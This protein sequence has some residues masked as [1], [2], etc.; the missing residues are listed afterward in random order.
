MG[1][2]E[3]PW[4]EGSPYRRRELW[5]KFI[6]WG[7]IAAGFCIGGALCYLSYA[8][9]PRH[10]F[11][12]IMDDHFDNLDNWEYEIQTGG[13]GVGAFDWTTND[14]QNSYVSNN[15]LHIVPTLTL[16]STAITPDELVNGYT[17]N[18]TLHGGCTSNVSTDCGVT[19]NS[20]SGVIINPVR[21]ARLTTK[22]KKTITY[23]RIEVVAKMPA[24]DWLWP[25]IWMMPQDSV[26]GPWPRSGEMDLFESRGNNPKHYGGGINTAISTLHWGLNLETDMFQLTS[27][28][29]ILRRSDYSKGFHTFGMEWT[30]NYIYTYIDSRLVR[31]ISVGFGGQNMWQ[32][33]GLSSGRYSAQDPWSQTGRDNTPFDQ[34]FYLILNVAVGGT[35]GYFQDGV[36]G[37]PW[38]DWD[39]TTAA[40]DF[41]MANATWLKT[42]APGEGRGMT[43]KS[44]K[45]WQLGACA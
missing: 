1:P 44:V 35:G 26:Y 21:S 17:L 18:L 32:R 2:Y 41:W 25:A 20:T 34:A 37:K 31:V 33:S 23:G 36:G 14:P 15:E 22:G 38:V 42:W 13:F 16:E 3:K 12:L 30:E 4:L 24:G 10:E 5:D 11:C 29:T 45:M 7:C 6:L 40:R 39:V 8:K 9:V 19:S 28:S 27:F 43:V